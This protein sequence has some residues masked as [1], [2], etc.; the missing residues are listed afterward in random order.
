MIIAY[1]IHENRRL[2]SSKENSENKSKERNNS[3][4]IYENPEKVKDDGIMNKWKMNSRR[5][6]LSTGV[7]RRKMMIIFMLI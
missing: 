5:I 7:G 3:K 4:D 2:K 1:L 6:Q